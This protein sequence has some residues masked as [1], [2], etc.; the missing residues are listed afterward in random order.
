MAQLVKDLE[1]SLQQFGLL[2]WSGFKP[3]PGNFHMPQGQQKK[4]K[5][6]DGNLRLSGKMTNMQNDIGYIGYYHEL[7]SEAKKRSWT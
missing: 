5:K 3:W 4:K 1:L 7:F 2:W 6:K